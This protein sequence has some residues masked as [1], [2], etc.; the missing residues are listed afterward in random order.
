MLLK[1]LMSLFEDTTVAFIV[2]IWFEPAELAAGQPHR[3]GAIEHLRSGKRH[4]FIDL[5]EIVHFI[6]AQLT[7]LGAESDRDQGSPT[8]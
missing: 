7:E 1:D 8:L 5:Q 2:R 3:R 6:A 4:Y